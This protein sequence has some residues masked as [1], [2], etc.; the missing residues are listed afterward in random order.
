[1]KSE[2]S[3]FENLY[4]TGDSDVESEKK[5]T[6]HFFSSPHLSF[7]LGISQ[8][9]RGKPPLSKGPFY[10]RMMKFVSDRELPPFLEENSV[11]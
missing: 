2:V 10:C 7:I 6:S 1:M 4:L 9:Y 8:V 5:K 11:P 3:A